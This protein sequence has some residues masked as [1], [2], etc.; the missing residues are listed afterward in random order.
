V[1]PHVGAAPAPS[2]QE[3]PLVEHA[4]AQTA[5]A[6]YEAD[7]VLPAAGAYGVLVRDQ[8]FAWE[9]ATASL[10]LEVGGG[11]VGAIPFILPPTA[12]GPR[13]LWTWLIWLVGLPIVAGLVVTVLVLTSRRTPPD[14][15]A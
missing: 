12:I 5:P 8:T 3:P 13:S 10:V 4:L 2:A 11:T 15:A 6:R 7:L 1:R 9:E 14:A